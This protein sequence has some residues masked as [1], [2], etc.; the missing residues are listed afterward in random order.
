MFITFTGVAFD[1]TVLI[2]VSLGWSR[3]ASMKRPSTFRAMGS[4]QTNS[5]A[6]TVHIKEVSVSDGRLLILHIRERPLVH[7]GFASSW[8]PSVAVGCPFVDWLWGQSP[9]VLRSAL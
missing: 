3:L 2:L 6:Q 5:F 4:M 8:L 1:P 9:R 7:E